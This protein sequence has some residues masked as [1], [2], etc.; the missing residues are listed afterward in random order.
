MWLVAGGLLGCVMRLFFYDSFEWPALLVAPIILALAS[1][2]TV[3]PFLIL[4]FTKAFYYERLKHLLRLPA[5]A[6][7]PAVPAPAPAAAR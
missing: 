3:L 4:S 2:V 7:T 6:A 1:F 5:A